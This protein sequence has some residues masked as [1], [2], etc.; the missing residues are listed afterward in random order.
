MKL[1]KVTIIIPVYNVEKYIRQCLNSVVS[2]TYKNL[3]IILID[4]ESP[5]LC[6]EIC[7]EYADKDKRITVFHQK[8]GG[9]A[10]ARNY[11]LEKATGDYICFVDSDDYVKPKYVEI[12]LQMAKENVADIAACSYVSIYPDTEE[13]QSLIV[14]REYTDREYLTEFTRNWTCGLIWNK[15]FSK[16]V[17]KDIRF[18]EGHRIDDEFFTYKVVMN[19]KKIITSRNELYAYRMR[20]SGVMLS[21]NQA[22][23]KMIQDRMEYLTERY[24]LVTE[25]YPE[26]KKIY[27]E[28]LADNMIRLKNEI[29][30]YSFD[31][32]NIKDIYKKYQKEILQGKISWKLKYAF[33]MSKWIDRK[34][35][36]EDNREL[37][38]YFE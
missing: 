36:V 6:P 26:L 31:S 32:K 14:D 19:S 34:G 29:T 21:E 23:E 17:I 9:A 5:D 35:L 18:S 13:H 25:R 22:K 33:L 4:D 15:I 3:E 20:A 1:E 11:G 37:M 28:N 27:L 10:N 12:L 8:N 24:D 30:S 38:D 16:N 7:E 2:Q